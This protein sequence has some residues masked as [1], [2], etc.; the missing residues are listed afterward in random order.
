MFKIAL[1]INHSLKGS[2]ATFYTK[3]LYTFNLTQGR[4]Q[5]KCVEIDNAQILITGGFTAN[6]ARFE[7]IFESHENCLSMM[8]DRIQ[9]K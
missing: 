6:W 4:L 1:T 2:K 3:D 5:P 9:Q 7:Y 8:F